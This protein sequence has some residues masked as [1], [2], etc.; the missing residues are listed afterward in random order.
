V[1]RARKLEGSVLLC[2]RFIPLA[3]AALDVAAVHMDHRAM[4]TG[5]AES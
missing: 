1:K 2:R 3:L 5:G 4:T